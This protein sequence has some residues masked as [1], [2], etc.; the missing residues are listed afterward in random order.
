MES[1][2]GKNKIVIG[3]QIFTKLNSHSRENFKKII[4]SDRWKLLLFPYCL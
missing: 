4:D 2:S 3:D 1:I